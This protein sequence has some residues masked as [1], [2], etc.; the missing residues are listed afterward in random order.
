MRGNVNRFN[1]KIE[2]NVR[3]LRVPVLSPKSLASFLSGMEYARGRIVRP[4]G[5][6]LTVYKLDTTRS[7]YND[8]SVQVSTGGEV[9]IYVNGVF[10]R[11][12]TDIEGVSDYIVKHLFFMETEEVEEEKI[13]ERAGEGW[14]LEV[15]KITEDFYKSAIRLL[16]SK[17]YNKYKRT[18]QSALVSK[19]YT[20]DLI[21]ETI[22]FGGWKRGV[23]RS[24]V[25]VMFSYLRVDETSGYKLIQEIEFEGN[26]KQ[27]FSIKHYNDFLR[28]VMNAIRAL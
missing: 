1:E 16:K 17:G 13:E 8:V 25:T 9:D 20:N 24:E 5:S 11:S 28:D 2:E 14:A 21:G 7:D 22:S 23:Y 4:D 6:V 19:E 10:H 12:F 26:L 15:T 27:E 3:A 18:I